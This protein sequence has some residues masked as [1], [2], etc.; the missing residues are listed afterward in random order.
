[1]NVSDLVLIENNAVNVNTILRV[2]FTPQDAID[3]TARPEL[4]AALQ[5][6]LTNDDTITLRGTKAET[7]WAWFNDHIYH[8]PY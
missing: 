8:V 6:K 5:I 2:T 3:E 7:L 4:G 1:M